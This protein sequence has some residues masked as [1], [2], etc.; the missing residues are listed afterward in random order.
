MLFKTMPTPFAAI[1]VGTVPGKTV[2]YRSLPIAI[3]T[4]NAQAHTVK[5]SFGVTP[6]TAYAQSAQPFGAWNMVTAYTEALRALAIARVSSDAQLA[7]AGA[8]ADVFD[9]TTYKPVDAAQAQESY[10]SEAEAEISLALELATEY[11]AL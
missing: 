5:A 7:I 9:V 3:A 8:A 2:A 11:S 10:L 1:A 6:L 4:A